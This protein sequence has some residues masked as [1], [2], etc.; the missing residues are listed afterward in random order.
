[1]KDRVSHVCRKNSK[2]ETSADSRQNSDCCGHTFHIRENVKHMAAEFSGFQR[3]VS[4]PYTAKGYMAPWSY[5]PALNWNFNW[6]SQV[7]QWHI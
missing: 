5:F 3:Q 2:T 4:S 7:V 1:M 6:N